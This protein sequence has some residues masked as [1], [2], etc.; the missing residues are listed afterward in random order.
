MS[1]ATTKIGYPVVSALNKP[2]WD[3]CERGELM[4]QFCRVCGKSQWYPRPLCVRCGRREIEWRK[5]MGGGSVYSF[6]IVRFPVQTYMNPVYFEGQ[7]PY[8]V[9]LIELNDEKI[10]MYARIV[11]CED[12]KVEI[13]MPVEVTFLKL[14]ENLHFP[15]FRPLRNPANT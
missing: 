6:T 11:E 3:G 15:A 14:K 5:A 4:I 10:R 8:V 2:F 9:G 12:S 13:G 1:N 7:F